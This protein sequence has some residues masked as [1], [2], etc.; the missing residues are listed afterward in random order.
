MFTPTVS[1]SR[2]HR[3]HNKQQTASP[4]RL[5]NAAHCVMLDVCHQEVCRVL[6][7]ISPLFI[8]YLSLPVSQSM[9]QYIPYCGLENSEHHSKMLSFSFLEDQQLRIMLSTLSCLFS[10]SKVTPS[11]C[12]RSSGSND[13]EGSMMHEDDESGD[14]DN[15]E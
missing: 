9:Y 8:S 3:N 2:W 1:F 5:I 15:N 7:P 4:P 14:N 13:N 10:L 11:L 6:L 12:Q